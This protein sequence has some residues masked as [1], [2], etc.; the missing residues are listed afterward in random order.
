MFRIC[1]GA[2][3][4]L[5]QGDYEYGLD[6]S[7]KISPLCSGKRERIKSLALDVLGEY[8]T[9][10]LPGNV[11]LEARLLGLR[12]E[13]VGLTAFVKVSEAPTAGRGVAVAVL[14]H[15]CSQNAVSLAAATFLADAVLKH[16]LGDHGAVRVGASPESLHGLFV[17]VKVKNSV[18]AGFHT[19]RLRKPTKSGWSKRTME[20]GPGTVTVRVRDR[21]LVGL[22]R[23]GLNERE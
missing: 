15:D 7:L 6:L 19:R 23:R 10:I 13:G 5:T 17:P 20:E 16:F 21:C 12:V 22:H 14:H 11:A 1:L 3:R 9:M 8:V 18:G 2:N 4:N